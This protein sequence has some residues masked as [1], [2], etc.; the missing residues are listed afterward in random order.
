MT[1]PEARRTVAVWRDDW[2]PGSETFIRNQ[3]AAM[4]RWTPR[5]VGLRPF[6]SVLSSDDDL[7]LFRGAG[8][9]DQARRQAFRLTRR[10]RRL[11][12]WLRSPDVKLVHA[13]FGQDATQ[14]VPTC[15]RLGL[16]LVA[17]FHGMD[18]TRRVDE[19]S[20]RT[21]R[22]VRARYAEV[23]EHA[24]RLIAVSEFIA[25]SLV[26]LGA[27]ERRIE[28]VP[29]GI[30]LPAVPAGPRPDPSAG[31]VFVGRLD[32]KKGV[33]DLFDAVAALP[34]PWRGVPVTVVGGGPLEQSLR[35]QATRLGIDARFLGAQPPARV[36]EI[37][38]EAY[39]FCAPSRT[40]PDGD[41]E[42]FGMVFLEAAARGLPVVSYRH[43]GVPE[44]VA[45]QETA[46]LAPEG[47]VAALGAALL[48]LLTDPERAARLGAAGEASA[49]A[50]FDIRS[51]T[52]RLE[53][54]Y[55]A[56]ATG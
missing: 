13:H 36:D 20:G 3:L 9:L 43:G 41:A 23:F 53:D 55:D 40:A 39:L 14:V 29:I 24:A 22:L 49:R 37:L 10:S 27:P 6:A 48:E 35:E 16:P 46:L 15:R 45:D 56:V 11:D 19:G 30:P 34:D 12:S 44:A 4:T 38:R 21:A 7:L 25:S 18:V 28:V 17:T 32:F 26:A 50:R 31:I 33:P 1:V 51:C 42:G 54:L 8:R 52:S 5:P 2:L 47:D